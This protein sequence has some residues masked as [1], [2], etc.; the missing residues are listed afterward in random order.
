VDEKSDLKDKTFANL[1]S[2]NIHYIIV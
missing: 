2:N 1:E